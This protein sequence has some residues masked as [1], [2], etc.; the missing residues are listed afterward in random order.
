MAT[1][2]TEVAGTAPGAH[3]R[4]MMTAVIGNGYPAVI[5]FFTGP[6]LAHAL[7][8]DGRGV[9]AAASAPLV[10]VTTIATFGIPEAVSFAVARN[11]HLVRAA[12]GRGILLLLVAGLIATLVVIL[13]T[14][15]LSGGRAAVERLIY[16]ACI[17]IV[18]SLLVSVLRG[19]ASAQQQ[20]RLVSLERIVSATMRLVVLVPFWLTGT[21]TPLIAVIA[22]TAVPVLGGLAYARVLGRRSLEPIEITTEAR[23]RGLG[24]FGSRIWLG[25]LSGIL[26]SRLD[27]TLMTPLAGTYELGLYVVAVSISE[28]PLIVNSAVR[29]V[30]FVSDATRSEDER[31]GASARIST[32]ISLLIGAIIGVSMI[33]LLPF[34]F[35]RAFVGALPVMAVLLAAV[36]LG[37]PGSIAGAGLSGRGRPGLRSAS[38]IVACIVNIALLVVLSPAFGAMGAAW[39]TLAGNLIASNLNLVFLR[40]VF[41]IPASRFYGIRRGDLRLL[42]RFARRMLPVR[43]IP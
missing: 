19:V 29:D 16:V 30:T 27:Q 1:S 33:W 35:G 37:T 40:K 25:S 22:M 6:I 39:A 32:F 5:A 11:R 17:A 14:P 7:G 24:S 2:G 26:L 12:A 10:L 41:G 34:L 4:N 9:V 8:V 23:L 36:V 20:W 28:L 15:L 3:S 21:L 13:A 38:L 43:R 31:L 42:I 18:P